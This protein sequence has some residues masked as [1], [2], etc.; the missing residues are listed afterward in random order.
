MNGVDGVNTAIRNVAWKVQKSFRSRGILGTA[1]RCMLELL[2]LAGLRSLARARRTDSGYEFDERYG[3]DTCGIID[4]GRLQVDSP[5]WRFGGSYQAI[6]PALFENIIT[7]L[8][9]RHDEYIFIDMGSGKGRALLLASAYPF[10]KIIGVEFVPKLHRVAVANIAKF[11]SEHRRCKDIR[12]VCMDAT[13][14]KIPPDP[15][16]Y[17][18]FNP[19]EARVMEAVLE[20]IERSFDNCSRSVWLV[21]VHTWT[22][23][24]AKEWK[25]FGRVYSNESDGRFSIYKNR[26]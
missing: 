22:D 15:V 12:S 6:A 19:F 2:A 8:N 11:R 13:A 26:V 16:V 1:A 18:F 20:N 7:R 17:Y 14:F 23:E 21:F 24:L 10:K 25:R 5:N 9:I 4:L 3:V